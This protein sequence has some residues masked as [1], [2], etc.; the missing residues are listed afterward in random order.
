M[1][2]GLSEWEGRP[3]IYPDPFFYFAKEG[4]F[5]P[6]RLLSNKL[7]KGTQSKAAAP[8]S[9]NVSQSQFFIQPETY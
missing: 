6:P 5:D 3:A 8:L 2:L 1:S 4:K 7:L 9:L